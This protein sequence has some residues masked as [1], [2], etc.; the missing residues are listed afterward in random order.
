MSHDDGPVGSDDADGRAEPADDSEKAKM[1][2]G[3]LYNASAPDLVEERLYA[4]GLTRLYNATG[5]RETA[6]REQLLTE[7]FGS[8]GDGIT[9]EPPF[10]CDYGYNIAVG[11]RFYANFGCVFLDVTPITFGDRCLLAPGVHVYTATHP[12]DAES[13]AEGL[14]AGDPVSV[15]DDVWIGGRTV[16]NPGVTVGDRA[17]VASGSV[18][19]KDVPADVLV[20]GN[21][22]RVIRELDTD[23]SSD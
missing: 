14:E 22:A 18:V 6:Q 23:A 2:R 19:T 12:L 17:V 10:R 4:R 8:V 9:V 16:V 7:L 20:G 11:D 5:P 13:R 1:L 15:G 3:D 21:P